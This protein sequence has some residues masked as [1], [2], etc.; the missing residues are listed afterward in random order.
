MTAVGHSFDLGRNFITTKPYID[1]TGP[2]YP[3]E[4]SVYMG[5]LSL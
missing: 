3:N 4:K 2:I 5:I 1:V